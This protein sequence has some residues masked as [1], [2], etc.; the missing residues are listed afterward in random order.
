MTW[1]D[2][3]GKHSKPHATTS[4]P[5]IPSAQQPRTQKK[6]GG[7]AG[8]QDGSVGNRWSSC[9][10]GHPFTFLIDDPSIPYRLGEK[11]MSG[12]VHTMVYWVGKFFSSQRMCV[13]IRRTS[14]REHTKQ[15]KIVRNPDITDLVRKFCFRALFFCI[16]TCLLSRT[17]EQIVRGW[18]S[19]LLHCVHI[20]AGQ[21]LLTFKEGR[22]PDRTV[23]SS[24]EP[25]S[26]TGT[27]LR[28]I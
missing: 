6:S 14:A 2:Q 21:Y 17:Q 20:G 28:W 1:D 9:G 25:T 27:L 12:N 7:L 24:V 4:N 16:C 5:G 3:S 26:D 8:E 19:L 13:Y 10:V 11:R 23:G 18:L 15:K 22:D